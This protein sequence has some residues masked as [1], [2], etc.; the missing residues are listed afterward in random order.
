MS[1]AGEPS[2]SLLVYRV[3]LDFRL[4]VTIHGFGSRE[5]MKEKDERP[6]AVC[7]RCA[8]SYF[9]PSSSLV[10]TLLMALKDIETCTLQVYNPFHKDYAAYI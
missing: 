2:S 9:P 4:R 8:T 3:E 1:A 6:D 7:D 5:T 10:S